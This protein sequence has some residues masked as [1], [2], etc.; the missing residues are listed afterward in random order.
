MSWTQIGSGLPSKTIRYASPSSFR[1]RGQAR[2]LLRALD[3]HRAGR[4]DLAAEPGQ[5]A[6]DA[7]V[8]EPGRGQ[9][10]G[11]PGEDDRQLAAVELVRRGERRGLVRARG[12]PPAGAGNGRAGLD[13][14]P[15]SSRARQARR[16]VGQQERQMPRAAVALDAGSRRRRRGRRRRGRS[17]RFGHGRRGEHDAFAGAR[18]VDRREQQWL[19]ERLLAPGFVLRSRRRSASARSRRR[20]RLGGPGRCDRSC[21]R[22]CRRSSARSRP[23]SHTPSRCPGWPPRSRPSTAATRPHCRV[24]SRPAARRTAHPPGCRFAGVVR[25]LHARRRPPRRPRRARTAPQALRDTHESA[26]S[27]LARNVRSINVYGQTDNWERFARGRFT[28]PGGAERPRDACGGA[29]GL[30]RGAV[31]GRGRRRVLGALRAVL[32]RAAGPAGFLVRVRSAVRFGVGG[33][34]C[35]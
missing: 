25:R 4:G 32:H 15:R 29:R 33:G 23:G 27:D 17:L 19:R 31:R 35:R 11:E 22:R 24:P 3:G 21:R 16:A 26:P 30:R 10:Q 7:A 14:R 18:V 13:R 6:G 5:R 9:E 2:D 1:R 28:L 34:C 12:H 8:H 20:S